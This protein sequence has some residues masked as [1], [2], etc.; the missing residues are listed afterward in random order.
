MNLKKKF[1]EIEQSAEYIKTLSKIDLEKYAKEFE[2][3]NYKKEIEKTKLVSAF[4]GTGKS[5][6]FNYSDKIVLD[7]DSSKF[8]K[9]DFPQNYIKHIKENIGKAN[10][11]C[12]SSH[13]EIRDALVKNGLW[14]TLVYPDK[15]LKEEYIQRFKD[16]GDK[17]SFINL[18]Y[19]N[20][21]EWLMQLRNQDN[22]IHIRLGIGEYISDI[23]EDL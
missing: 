10:I 18:I 8:D 4:P 1:D 15:N 12:I 6:L 23:I 7:S 21:D 17:E 22:C 3:N 11:I 20:W 16:R 19:N 5:Y 9:K 14:F 2:N 13:K